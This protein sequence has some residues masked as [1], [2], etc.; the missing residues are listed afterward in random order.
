MSGRKVSVFLAFLLFFFL[1]SSE[2]G[3]A[4]KLMV[5]GKNAAVNPRTQD[6]YD[7]YCDRNSYRSCLP[8]ACDPY[9]EYCPPKN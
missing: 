2:L 9:V 6:S 3:A 4:R 5:A 1:V 8:Q 7:P